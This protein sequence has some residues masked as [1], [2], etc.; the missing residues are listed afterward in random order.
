LQVQVFV[1]LVGAIV[2]RIEKTA[3]REEPNVVVL[4]GKQIEHFL[5]TAHALDDTVDILNVLL[6]HQVKTGNLQLVLQPNVVVKVEIEMVVPVI[7]RK[8]VFVSW[9]NVGVGKRLS[10]EEI[11]VANSGDDDTSGLGAFH[12]LR[13]VVGQ[14]RCCINNRK[15]TFFL[16]CLGLKPIEKDEEKHKN[17]LNTQSHLR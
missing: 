15:K 1:D 9:V 14:A 5:V 7:V 3:L 12:Y 2:V 10:V 11:K 17:F 8:L 4:V 6:H 16:F 13:T